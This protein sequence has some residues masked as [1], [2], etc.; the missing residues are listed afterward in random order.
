M[1]N[2][3]RKIKKSR[4]ILAGILTAMIFV[5]GLMVGLVIE[6]KR[7]QFI[8]GYSKELKLDIGSLQLQYAFIDQLAQAGNCGAFT[9]SFDKNL[10]K[11]EATRLKLVS[12]QAD[13]TV[14]RHE[15]NLLRRNYILSQVEYWLLSIK[16][17]RLCGTDVVNVLY[18]FSKDCSRCDDQSFVLTFLKQ[19]FR[20]RLFVFGF[21]ASFEDEPL[22][23]L[24]TATYNVTAYPTV[25]I[26]GSSYADFMSKENLTE[27]LCGLYVDK[28]G[29]CRKGQE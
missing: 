4:Y 8:D 26:E 21:D 2:Y 16:A 27:T 13:A 15:F 7:V 22:L 23:S 28:P 11:L 17:K 14:N 12:Y 6:G 29:E 18:F 9:K 19:K 24:M 20:D 10:E 25:I 3:V 5:V 1:E